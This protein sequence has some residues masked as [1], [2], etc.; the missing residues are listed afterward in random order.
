MEFLLPVAF[1]LLTWWA[2]TLLML[3]RSTRARLRCPVTLAGI[4]VIALAGLAG[5]VLLRDQATELAAYGAFVSGLAVW[6][7]LELT[8]F[9]GWITGPR[10][11]ACP[12]SL[13]TA[14]RFIYGIKTS[15]YHELSIVLA[16]LLILAI[17]HGAVNQVGMW[18]FMI[19]WLMRWSAKL[20]IFLGVRNLHH[21]FWPEHLQYLG[22][23][24]REAGMN[25]LFPWSML[26]AAIGLAW[27]I[28][29]AFSAQPGS[30]EYTGGLILA[31]LLALAALEHVFLVIRV[32]DAVLWRWASDSTSPLAT[33]H[34][35][36]EVRAGEGS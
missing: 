15:L 19:L 26:G 18:T 20:N 34:M 14:R 24:V 9:L 8:Y 29:G 22:S 21:E 3:R 13:T 35:N 33:S 28:N 31:T 7:W 36:A 27:L 2:T 32:P 5:M 6:A 4:S 17:N 25:P 12:P 30:M 1:T 23:Y 16:A 11:E 10:P